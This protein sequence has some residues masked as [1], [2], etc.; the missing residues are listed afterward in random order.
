MYLCA[1]AC[2]CACVCDPGK[3]RT[4]E[5]SALSYYISGVDVYQC[6]RHS[7]GSVRSIAVIAAKRLADP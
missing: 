4:N 2:V 5:A 3:V 1:C 6:D 7:G